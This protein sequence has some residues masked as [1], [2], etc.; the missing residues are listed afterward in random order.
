MHYRPLA[1]TGLEL[2]ALGLGCAGYWG[3]RVFSER[4]AVDIVHR[5]LDL[6]ITLF[7]TGSSYSGGNAEPRLG[8]ALIGR[9][10]SKL[11]ISSKAGT[12]IGRGG[13]LYND[14]SP[15]WI[16]YSL[17]QSLR[18][19]RLEA[20]PILQLHGPALSDLTPELMETLARL[21]ERGL[22]RLLGI[23]SFDDDVLDA[24]TGMP[25]LDLVMLDY[26]LLRLERRAQIDAL[27]QAGKT[28]LAA[29]P[30]AGGV[31]G[32]RLYKLR[33]PRDLWY[34]LRALKNQRHNIKRAREL[35]KRLATRDW[36]LE[37]IAIN[38]A[39]RNE[40]VASVVM[41]TTDIEHLT[42]NI[43]T[44]ERTLPDELAVLVEGTEGV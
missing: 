29:A 16:S 28:V 13:R 20:L 3:K 19:L 21:R 33:G 39:A 10:T 4:R 11:I 24:A 14:F 43:R 18:Q 22:F 34:L 15:A 17:E 5:A 42:H 31:L 37:Q 30:L 41:G 26:N 32:N 23:N 40:H 9:D 36:K 38:Y 35:A 1:A 27:A 12:R 6:G 7:D 8:R 44:M 25:A 2:S